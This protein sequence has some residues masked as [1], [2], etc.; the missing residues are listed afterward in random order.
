MESLK[1]HFAA[2]LNRLF[3]LAKRDVSVKD[4]SIPDPQ[5]TVAK[6][7]PLSGTIWY[8]SL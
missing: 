3:C 2:D 6:P 1:V 4:S 8:V 7:S 5:L